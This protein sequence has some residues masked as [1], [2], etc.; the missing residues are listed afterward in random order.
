MPDS[1]EVVEFT[2]REG[3]AR[4]IDYF[5]G[6]KCK[7]RP[8]ETFFPPKRVQPESYQKFCRGCPIQE[9]CLD[10]AMC[11]DSYGV[12]G[13]L[14]RKQRQNIPAAYKSEAERRGKEEGWY[15]ILQ[16]VENAVDALVDA[17]IAEQESSTSLGRTDFNQLSY[18]ELNDMLGI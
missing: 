2:K 6:A 3:A 4:A 15:W 10:F 8:V 16:D 7:G 5:R 12:W 14:T 13:G 1:S 9:F 11:F 18:A 17:V